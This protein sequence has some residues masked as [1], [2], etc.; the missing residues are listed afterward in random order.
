MRSSLIH[1]VAFL[2]ALPASPLQADRRAPEA[3]LD[4]AIRTPGTWSQMC[5]VPFLD[6]ETTLPLYGLLGPSHFRFEPETLAGLR[7]RRVIDWTRAFVKQPL[8]ERFGA[9]GM[10][11]RPYLR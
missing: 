4:E 10:S 1:V 2:A 6:P 7:T 9:K 5:A 11:P 8:G 3:L